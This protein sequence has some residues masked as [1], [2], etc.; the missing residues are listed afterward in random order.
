MALSVIV[1]VLRAD[2]GAAFGD[3]AEADPE[4]VAEDVDPVLVVEGMHLQPGDA[5]EEAG[6]PEPVRL[7]VLAQ[8]VADVLA[9]EALDA[10]AELLDP[11]GLLLGEGPVG[12]LAGA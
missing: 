5:D 12:A 10:L 7:L 1:I 4:F 2:L 3:V 8:D 11:V 6:P 9:Q